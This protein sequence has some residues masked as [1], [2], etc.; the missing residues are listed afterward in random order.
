MISTGADHTRVIFDQ[1]LSTDRRTKIDISICFMTSHRALFQAL[2]SSVIATFST[3][4]SVT[5]IKLLPRQA[6]NAAKKY[7]IP[8]CFSSL[9][10]IETID[11]DG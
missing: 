10:T 9:G 11:R 2:K 5:H 6:A 4:G 1:K 8:S 7:D 3:V